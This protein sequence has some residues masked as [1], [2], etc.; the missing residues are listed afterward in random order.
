MRK[1]S[2]LL[3]GT[4][5]LLLI[6]MGRWIFLSPQ[7]S[8]K[9]MLQPIA[10]EM[11]DPLLRFLSVPSSVAV[12]TG[13]EP[14]PNVEALV[15]ALVASL[16]GAGISVVDVNYVEGDPEL[17][18]WREAGKIPY[19]HLLDTLKIHPDLDTVISFQGLPIYRKTD[20]NRMQDQLKC[21]AVNV[22]SDLLP[23][24][25]AMVNHG[26]LQAFTY[27]NEAGDYVLYP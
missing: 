9:K 21:I 14:S 1:S 12:V 5:V 23:E 2:I 22:N 4:A 18:Y 24:A 11:A 6:F 27:V 25:K 20:S 3:G 26:V 8:N 19:H 15:K 17:A 7:S 13:L 16:E 10:D